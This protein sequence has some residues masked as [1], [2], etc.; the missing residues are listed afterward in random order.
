MWIVVSTGATL[1]SAET[2]S[3]KSESGRT[4]AV[5]PERPFT[6]MSGPRKVTAEG[7]F[8]HLLVESAGIS[9][10]LPTGAT[11]PGRR[12]ARTFPLLP[13]PQKN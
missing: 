3:T 4:D 5:D 11:R 13:P 10:P 9:K 2:I 1:P 12:T 8:D 7:R 6:S